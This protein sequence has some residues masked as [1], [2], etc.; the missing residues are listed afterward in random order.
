MGMIFF[1]SGCLHPYGWGF[2]H[3]QPVGTLSKSIISQLCPA[4]DTSAGRV[5]PSSWCQE[6]S[7]AAVMLSE[8]S[9]EGFPSHQGALRVDYV[10]FTAVLSWWSS[11]KIREH[12]EGLRPM[13]CSSLPSSRDNFDPIKCIKQI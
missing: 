6:A 3:A 1:P 5:L 9:G 4:L 10:G 2:A 13:D 12:R 11:I 8:G 7:V